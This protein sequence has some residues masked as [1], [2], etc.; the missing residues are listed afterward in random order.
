[1]LRLIYVSLDTS[2]TC[3][4]AYTIGKLLRRASPLIDGV[5]RSANPCA[6]TQQAASSLQRQADAASSACHEQ[7]MRHLLMTSTAAYASA[8]TPRHV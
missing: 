6:C 1:M 3:V 8:V 2:S 7:M 5:E 4:H